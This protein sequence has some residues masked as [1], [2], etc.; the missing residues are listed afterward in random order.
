M[1]FSCVSTDA[2]N[3]R[4]MFAV[5]ALVFVVLAAFLGIFI[6]RLTKTGTAG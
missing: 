3:R 1:P 6:H 4:G 2:H 5:A